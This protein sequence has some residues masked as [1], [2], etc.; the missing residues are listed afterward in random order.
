MKPGIFY[1]YEYNNSQK[2]RNAG[3]LKITRYYHSCTLM[4]NARGIPAAYS[5]TI[6]LCAFYQENGQTNS[7]VLAEITCTNRAFSARLNSAESRFPEGRTLDMIDGFFLPLPNGHVLAAA[8]PGITVDTE[9]L[10][11][12]SSERAASEIDVSDESPSGENF[13]D[14]L[15][16][17]APPSRRGTNPK[18]PFGYTLS[19]EVRPTRRDMRQGMPFGYTFAELEAESLQECGAEEPEAPDS[20]GSGPENSENTAL[21]E[22]NSS[23]EQNFPNE[24][25]TPAEQKCSSEPDYKSEPE[26]PSE[27]CAPA[28]QT[29][30]DGQNPATEQPSHV[31]Q[32]PSAEQSSC[33]GQNPDAEQSSCGGQNP[34]AEQSSCSGQNPDA[35]QDSS[36]KQISPTQTVKKIQRSDMTILP[37]RYWHL[38]NNSFLLHG[39]HNYH[40]LILIEKDGHYW[41]GVPGIYD[42]REARA[43]RLFGFPQFTDSYNDSLQLTDEE[44]NPHENFGYWCCYLKSKP[45][46]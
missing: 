30:H 37:R 8:A 41:L 45:P 14:A 31:E 46:Q 23:A 3:F 20:T 7:A 43:A 17:E 12:A 40:H 32:N 29:P 19:D 1:L 18:T 6:K 5:D 24:Q 33:S 36:A 21:P 22:Q 38:A 13:S 39:Y 28:E 10:L 44:C 26:C 34:D 11:A 27:L 35:K 4:L 15:S 42:P 2:L 25:N 9:K 16:D